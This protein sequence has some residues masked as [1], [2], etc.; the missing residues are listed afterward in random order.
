[1][2]K[3]LSSIPHLVKEWHP[4][5]NG[6]LTPA[7]FTHGTKNKVWWLCSEGHT[8]DAAI[9]NRTNKN[10]PTGCPYCSGRSSLNYDLFKQQK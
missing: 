8:Y 7:N 10:A 6:D 9:K 5:K 2:K 3:L 1:M 4:S